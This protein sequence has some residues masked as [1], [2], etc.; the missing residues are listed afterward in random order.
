MVRQLRRE[1]EEKVKKEKEESKSNNG[2][3]IAVADA[4]A[5][6]FHITGSLDRTYAEFC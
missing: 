1:Q 5:H 6:D 4:K 3:H 2:Q